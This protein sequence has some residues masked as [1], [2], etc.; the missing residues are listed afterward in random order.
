[1]PP[2]NE[3][4]IATTQSENA[5]EGHSK[6]GR[7]VVGSSETHYGIRGHSRDFAGIRGSSDLSRGV[8]GFAERSEGVAGYS[9]AGNGVWG[10]SRNDG[11]GV[12]GTSA[13][14]IGVYGESRTGVFARS[15]DGEAVH[16]E[17]R[18]PVFAAVAGYHLNPTSGGA[19]IF[20]FSTSSRGHAGYFVGNVEINGILRV[21]G[22]EIDP[23]QL[24]NV[25]SSVGSLA[26]RVAALEDMVGSLQRSVSYLLTAVHFH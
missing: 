7:G 21:R 22:R 14:G 8:E 12:V 3:P 24:A 15:A 9:A 5:V 4:V 23:V 20:G 11:I 18:S 10:A 16:A 13:G 6:S 17:T 19:A 26:Q 2:F 1:M 25:G